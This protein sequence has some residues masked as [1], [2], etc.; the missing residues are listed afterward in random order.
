M[1]NNLF[2]AKKQEPKK[3]LDAHA[4]SEQLAQKIEDIGIRI[5]KMDNDSAELK[6]KA[7]AK[8][9]AGDNRGAIVLLKKSKM[10][11]KEL[12]KLEGQMMMLEQQQMMIQ[13]AEFDN[14]V[15]QGMKEGKDVMQNL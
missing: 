7:V 3:N 13:S 9:K 11:E 12:A 6:K 5:K 15:F 14:G 2:G 1:F 10:Y 8:K 4:V